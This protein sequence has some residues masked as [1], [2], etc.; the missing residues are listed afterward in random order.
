MWGKQLYANNTPAIVPANGL[1]W[2]SAASA[3]S[4]IG[5]SAGVIA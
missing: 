1:I 2:R 4:Q 3:R 5:A